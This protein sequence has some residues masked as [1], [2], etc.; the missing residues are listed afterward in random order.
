MTLAPI[1]GPGQRGSYVLGPKTLVPIGLIAVAFGLGFGVANWNSTQRADV[2]ERIERQHDELAEVRVQVATVKAAVDFTRT[3]I[4][5]KLDAIA[6][7][8]VALNARVDADLTKDQFDAYVRLA[9]AVNP[10]ITWPERK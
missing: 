3:E 6:A 7:S 5:A 8:Q 9:R 1:D 4:M 2:A 10:Q